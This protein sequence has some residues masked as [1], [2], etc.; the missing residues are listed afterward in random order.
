LESHRERLERRK[1]VIDAGRKWYEIWVPHNPADWQK[2]KIVFPDIA[3]HAQFFL[4]RSGAIVNGDCYWITQK[5]RQDPAWLMLML[6]IANSSF[7]TQ[8][9]DIM[10][11]NK[12][13]SGRRRFMAQYVSRFPLPCLESSP[14]KEIV[15]RVSK[16][17]NGRRIDEQAEKEVDRL[18]F[19]S[20]GLLEEIGR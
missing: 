1:Y 6:A 20:F 7:I 10:F 18:V 4:D 5:P 19:E 8:Y 13:Y 3:E 12:L 15:R 17:V 16:F 9:Y 2:P 11:H 14:A